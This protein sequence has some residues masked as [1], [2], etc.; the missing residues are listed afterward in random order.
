MPSRRFDALLFDLGST[1]IYFDAQWPE[2]LPQADAELVRRL[3]AAGLLKDAQDFTQKYRARIEE[4]YSQRELEF[5]EYTTAY[6]LRDILEEY[7]YPQVPDELIQEALTAMYTVT[8]AYWMPELDANPTLQ[9]LRD[10]GYRIGLISN[11]ADDRDVQ[12]LIDKAALRPYFEVI[13]TSAAEGIRKPNPRIFHKALE[14]LGVRPERAAMIG[15]TLGADILGA[16][17][18]GIYAIWITRR[19]DSPANRDHLDTIQPDAVIDSLG[20]LPGLLER[21]EDRD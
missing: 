8:Q 11:A 15:D 14:S 12:T 20:E 13:L 10:Q 18:A 6:I 2:I 17:N 3:Q 1:L 5:I 7:G 21:L 16:K 4:Y 19:A 9:G